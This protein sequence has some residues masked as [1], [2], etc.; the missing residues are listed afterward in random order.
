MDR[1]RSGKLVSVI[2]LSLAHGYWVHRTLQI[3]FDGFEVGVGEGQT[4]AALPPFAFL[5]AGHSWRLIGSS[6]AGPGRRGS[7][8]ESPALVPFQSPARLCANGT[9]L[10]PRPPRHCLPLDFPT[11][12][13]AWPRS[14]LAWSTW[15][16]IM[17]STV[18]Y[19][20]PASVT[21]R[22]VQP[23]NVKE[24]GLYSRSTRSRRV[25]CAKICVL[26]WPGGKV[27]VGA[28]SS[29]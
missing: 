29:C 7:S 24:L 18:L 6:G 27:V 15:G 1:V 8:S 23:R 10:H 17:R 4:T 20:C 22:H 25:D 16:A 19:R 21:S 13:G 12:K 3:V 2:L 14:P 26:D 11:P 28:A 9:S 5:S